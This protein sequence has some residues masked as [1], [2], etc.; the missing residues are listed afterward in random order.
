MAIK[1]FEKLSNN[2]LEL[3]DDKE[4]FNIVIN[5]GESPNAKIFQAHSAILKYRS[6]YFCNE[7]SNIRK[8]ANNIKTLN[9]TNLTIQQFEIIIKYIYGGIV[10]LENHNALFIF[11]LMLIACEFLFDELAKY[12]ETHLI[13]TKARWLR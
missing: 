4:D 7:L 11:E 1:F 6:L 10:L 5:V 2:Y 9:L 3:L 12:L 8:D 13:E